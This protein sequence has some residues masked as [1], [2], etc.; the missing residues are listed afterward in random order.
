MNKL[1]KK[2]WRIEIHV[3]GDKSVDI[4]LEALEKCD[5]GRVSENIFILS[6]QH[7]L[8][9]DEIRPF[10]HILNHSQMIRADQIPIIKKY[11]LSCSIQARVIAEI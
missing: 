10:R 2:G 1:H 6:R 7:I 3:I 8:G 9:V 4:F 5:L 11:G